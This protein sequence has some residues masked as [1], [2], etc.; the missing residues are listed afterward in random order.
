MAETGGLAPQPFQ[1]RLL[2]KQ[3]RS[4]IGS[5]SECS[6]LPLRAT[7]SFQRGVQ[8]REQVKKGQACYRYTRMA[9][10]RIHAATSLRIRTDLLGFSWCLYV[11]L[12]HGLWLMKPPSY[13]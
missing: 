10:R 6:L 3:G 8:N 13:C 9:E 12:P 1:T 7:L 11:V 5:V 4:L 2:S